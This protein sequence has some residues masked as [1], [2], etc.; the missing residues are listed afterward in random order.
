MTRYFK[1]QA[2]FISG[3]AGGTEKVTIYGTTS[4]TQNLLTQNTDQPLLYNNQTIATTVTVT[5]PLGGMYGGGVV[6]SMDDNVNNKWTVTADYF[7]LSTVTWRQFYTAHGPD[8]GQSWTERI[9][10]PY[11]PVRFN[12]RNDDTVSHTFI[13]SVIAL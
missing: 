7:D 11:A 9:S 1:V 12:Q 6:V 2:T 5:L 10:L 8:K 3:V 13:L 4:D